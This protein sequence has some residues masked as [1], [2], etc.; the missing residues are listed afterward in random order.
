VPNYKG[1]SH[2]SVINN[3]GISLLCRTIGQSV[4]QLELLRP[5]GSQ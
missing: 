1:F 2:L 5:S 4:N 3:K